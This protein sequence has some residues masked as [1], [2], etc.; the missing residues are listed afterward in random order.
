MQRPKGGEAREGS[1]RFEALLVP[2]GQRQ[3]KAK[4]RWETAENRPNNTQV[5]ALSFVIYLG[6]KAASVLLLFSHY[7]MSN[8]LRPHGLQPARFRCPWDSPRQ[9]YRSGL[10]FPFW[11][12]LPYL[13]IKS[14]SPA[15]QVDSLPLSHL[16]SPTRTQKVVKRLWISFKRNLLPCQLLPMILP[17]Y[18][19]L[20]WDLND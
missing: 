17:V 13:G 7:V 10:P 4:Q 1:G 20:L 12:N 16:G 18:A 3:S 2:G 11:G 19:I 14:M 6:H 8:S 5:K 15:W 9:E